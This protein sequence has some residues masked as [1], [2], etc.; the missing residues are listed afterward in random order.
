[1]NSLG[2]NKKIKIKMT[3]YQLLYYLIFQLVTTTLYIILD[4]LLLQKV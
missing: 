3:K 2:I 4:T 1:M